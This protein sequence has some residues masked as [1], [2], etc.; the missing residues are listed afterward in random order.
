MTSGASFREDA[1]KEVRSDE[2][3]VGGVYFHF[4]NRGSRQILW[5]WRSGY[6]VS[7]ISRAARQIVHADMLHG[8]HSGIEGG[9]D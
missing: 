1:T 3:Q 5:R 2:T 4:G 7:K 6:L 8:V 9:N